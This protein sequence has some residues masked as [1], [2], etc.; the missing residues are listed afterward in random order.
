MADG[1]TLEAGTAMAP[2]TSYLTGTGDLR[3]GGTF[4]SHGDFVMD[5]GVLKTMGSPDSRIALD[6]GDTF[7]LL[8]GTVL[9]SPAVSGGMFL[10]GTGPLQP[11]PVTPISSGL[12][13]SPIAAPRRRV[14]MWPRRASPAASPPVIRWI[15]P[16]RFPNIVTC[17]TRHIREK[18]RRSVQAN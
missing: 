1:A 2:A 5:G 16:T 17:P 3:L 18:V 15:P 9:G 14:T 12:R 13:C 4:R 6:A 11:S 8:G 7:F 10:V